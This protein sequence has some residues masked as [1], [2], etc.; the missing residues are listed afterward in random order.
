MSMIANIEA[1]YDYLAPMP[2]YLEMSAHD[3]Y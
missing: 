2:S 3:C 1:S